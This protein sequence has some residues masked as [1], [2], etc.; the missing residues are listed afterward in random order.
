MLCLDNL[1]T[2]SKNNIKHLLGNR[3]FSFINHDITMPIDL[4]IDFIMNFAC[5]ASPKHYQFN[6][7]QTVKTNV[8]GSINMLE[9]A[10]KNRYQFC[11]HQ[12]AKYM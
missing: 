9:L 12:Q 11:K 1:F 7:V 10:R 2:G 8:H 3:N 6:P 5:P 4:D